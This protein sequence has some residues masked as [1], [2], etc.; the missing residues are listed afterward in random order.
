MALIGAT[1][2]L[3]PP[4]ALNKI[5]DFMENYDPDTSEGVP[6]IVVCSVAGLFISQVSYAT[7]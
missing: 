4:L 6:F 5:T 2:Q 7:A 1:M 3:I